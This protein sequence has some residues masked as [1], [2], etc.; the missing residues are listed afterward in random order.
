MIALIALAFAEDPVMAGLSAELDRSMAEL[1]LPDSPTPYFISYRLEDGWY[2]RVRA[3]LGAIVEESTGPR[4]DLGVEV[5]VGSEAYDSANFQAGFRSEDGHVDRSL[6]IADHELAI[7][8]D[9]WLATDQAYKD[10]VSNLS[11][12]EAADGRRAE[13]D[14]T[15]DFAPGPPS[16]FSAPPAA[17]PDLSRYRQIAA[18]ISERFLEHPDIELSSVTVYGFGGR[19]GVMDSGGTQVQIPLSRVDITLSAQTR[20]PDGERITDLRKLHLRTL[21]TL[22]DLD[23]IATEL[24]TALEDWKRAE[25][26]DE[27]YIGPLLVESTASPTLF[28]RLALPS[29][30]GTPVPDR[31][32]KGSR[33]LD[34]QNDST[35]LLGLKRRL[36]PI[37]WSVVDDPLSNPGSSAAFTHDQEGVP[38]QRVELVSDGIVRSHYSSRTPSKSV[39]QSNGHARGGLG[40]LLK[41]APS[42]TVVSAP[43]TASARK[44]HKTAMAITN[45]YGNDHYLVVRRFR[46]GSADTG[47]RLGPARQSPLQDASILLRVYGDG[48]E[49]LVRGATIDGLQRRSLRDIV[50]AGSAGTETSTW[51]G[52]PVQITA[53]AVLIDEVEVRPTEESAE[54]PPP[55]AS[56]L[57]R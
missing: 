19:Y 28:R 18:Q 17:R 22:P 51:G 7:R 23:V 26:L 46:D 44:L 32:S 30:V 48:R 49:E 5:R 25:A 47:F 11:A 31:P 36:L 20:A 50:A 53:P 40:T 13:V 56:P 57:A 37:G 35:E 27:S 54:K 43:R 14:P 2:A 29:L 21:D 55:L 16:E 1:S 8:S 52:D 34:I 38:A 15:P 39:P 12:K 42:I 4:R 45:T 9:A 10:A 24:A 41:G 3:S 33:F 6:V